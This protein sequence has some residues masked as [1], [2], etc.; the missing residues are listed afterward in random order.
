MM[1]L[2]QQ[3]GEMMMA[4]FEGLEAPAHILEW[5]RAGRIGGVILFARNVDSPAQ[6]LRLT[7]AL[8]EAAGRPILI[9]IDQEGGTVARL[10]SGFTESPG[11]MAISACSEDAEGYS[12]RVSA[13]LGA[14]MRALGI[15]WTFA[16]VLDI[17]HDIR[18]PSVGTRSYGNDRERVGLLATAAV[19][20]FESA[21]VA[22]CLKHFP[23]LG[24]SLVDTHVD[25][26]VISGPVDDLYRTDLIPFRRVIQSGV[27]SVMI[28]HVKFD[29]L[30]TENPATMAGAVVEGL[31][32]DTLDYEALVTTDCMEMKAIT[33]YFG[34]GEAAVRSVLAGIDVVLNSHTVEAQT[35]AYEAVLSAVK[36][37]RIP[38]ERISE[39]NRRIAAM[40]ARFA[41]EDAER[42]ALSSIRSEA[43]LA[44][45]REAARAGCVLMAEGEF[46]AEQQSSKGAEGIFPLP[47]GLGKR[48]ALIEFASAMDSE[49]MDTT[50]TTA[51]S[52]I[53]RERLP[54]VSIFSIAPGAVPTEI[55]QSALEQAASADT[56]VLATRNAHLN[57][58]QQALASDLLTEHGSKTILL[59]LRNPYDAGLLPTRAF[60]LF[61]CGDA[62][63][64]LEAAADALAGAFTPSGVLPVPL[65]AGLAVT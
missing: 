36:S 16:P 28:T 48:I 4:G 35:A 18:N 22:A 12:E 27:A 3:V 49:A 50:G 26:A 34:S 25:L 30:D 42:P 5:L 47:L 11:A 60:T 38:L 20:G 24:K 7:H 39:S 33:R 45:V 41:G 9:G 57:P 46:T 37:G 8:R 64:S 61:T 1:T 17:T 23:G 32:R 63:P 58:A 52:S 56:I 10:R 65:A 43:H 40:K 59:C 21:G 31:L 44:T 62:T 2:E 51:F 55:Q 15:N 54:E 53:V 19:R 6:V 13:V 29:A 14:E